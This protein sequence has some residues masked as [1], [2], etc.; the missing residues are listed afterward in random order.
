MF[1]DISFPAFLR[2]CVGFLLLTL[3]KDY[4]IIIICRKLLKNRYFLGKERIK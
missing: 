3:V 1:I 4:G 2:Y